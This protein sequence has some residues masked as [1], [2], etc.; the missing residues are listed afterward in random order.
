MMLN[1]ESRIGTGLPL[2]L[3][4]TVAAFLIFHLNEALIF[5]ITFVSWMVSHEWL[6][7]ASW[8]VQYTAL[9]APAVILV[10]VA[11]QHAGA[12]WFAQ[13]P[14]AGRAIHLV[15]GVGRQ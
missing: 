11:F 6:W 3:A 7:I 4:V 10:Y 2:A 8:V 12:V 1:S 15:S 5:D 14:H 13:W 9:Y